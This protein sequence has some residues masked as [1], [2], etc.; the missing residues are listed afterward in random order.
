MRLVMWLNLLSGITIQ[1]HRVVEEKNKTIAV[2][3]QLFKQ[4]KTHLIQLESA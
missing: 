4:T 3:N 1:P 2:T